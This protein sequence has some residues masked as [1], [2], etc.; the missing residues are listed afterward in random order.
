MMMLMLVQRHRCTTIAELDREAVREGIFKHVMRLLVAGLA[1]SIVQHVDAHIP[2]P[3]GLTA[4]PSSFSDQCIPQCVSQSD[5]CAY[6]RILA[7]CIRSRRDLSGNL[8]TLTYPG[9]ATITCGYDAEDRLVKLTNNLAGGVFS[10]NYDAVGRLQGIDYPN[11]AVATNVWGLAHRLTEFRHSKG[12]A[13]VLRRLAYDD[14][15]RPIREEID[16]G[17]TPKPTG[18]SWRQETCDLAGR[19]G[20]SVNVR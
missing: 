14:G 3:N 15:D 4:S 20:R 1:F 19:Y 6:R 2:C 11:G 7:N 16:A 13:F 12:G 10:F 5:Q 8:T 18:R 9:R 17:A